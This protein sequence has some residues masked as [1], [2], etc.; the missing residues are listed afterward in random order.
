MKMLLLKSSAQF[1]DLHLE[2][3][4]E[5]QLRPLV[6]DDIYFLK[7]SFISWGVGGRC[8]SDRMVIGFTTTYAISA[9]HDLS[10]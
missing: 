6:Y 10:C 3:N 1:W 9:Y 5:G 4:S 2:I 8:S 7:L